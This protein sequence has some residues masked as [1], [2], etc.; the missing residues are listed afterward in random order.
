MRDFFGIDKALHPPETGAH[1]LPSQP[2][3]DPDSIIKRIKQP[4]KK[5]SKLVDH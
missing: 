4:P 3:V 1:K 2:Q 5:V